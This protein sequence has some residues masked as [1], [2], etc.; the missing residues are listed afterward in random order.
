MA[1]NEF[2]LNV[3]RARA[4]AD[5]ASDVQSRYDDM[6]SRVAMYAGYLAEEMEKP[7]EERNRWQ[8][9]DYNDS[10]R[11]FQMQADLWEGFL[12]ALKKKLIA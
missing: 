2:E 9:D 11:L 3:T 12:K 6:Q 4:L 7:E 10:I 5:V 1:A 8:V